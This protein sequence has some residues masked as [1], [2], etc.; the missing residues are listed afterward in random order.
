MRIFTFNFKIGKFVV[1]KAEILFFFILC[2]AESVHPLCFFAY[3]LKL[4]YFSIY[5]YAFFDGTLWNFCQKRHRVKKDTASKRAFSEQ[6]FRFV[7]TKRHLFN[8]IWNFCQI[9]RHLVKKRGPCRKPIKNKKWKKNCQ[10]RREGCILKF[11]NYTCQKRK[12]GVYN[13]IVIVV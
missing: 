9:K 10:K 1:I 5:P 6:N 12:R 11:N 2:C 3:M 13:E 7:S 4:L 8:K